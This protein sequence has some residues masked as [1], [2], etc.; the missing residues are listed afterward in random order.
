MDFKA[1]LEKRAA[2]LKTELEAFT[3]SANSRILMYKAAI[4]EI[5]H[6]LA[7]LNAEEIKETPEVSD[8]QVLG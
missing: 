6:L 2:D 4:G 7:E 5:E 8:N 3:V 1:K